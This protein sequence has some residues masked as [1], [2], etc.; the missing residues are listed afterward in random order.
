[1]FR[2]SGNVSCSHF[3]VKDGSCHPV[4]HQQCCPKHCTSPELPKPAEI[5]CW[6]TQT[7]PAPPR[8]P[9]NPSPKGSGAQTSRSGFSWIQ[10]GSSYILKL[11]DTLPCASSA[12]GGIE[13]FNSQTSG[14]RREGRE[15][16]GEGEGWDSPTSLSTGTAW[17][18]PAAK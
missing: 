6:D 2:L 12:P 11:W 13:E 18:L 1:M 3:S 10:I 7:C 8:H 4:R 9:C 15:R 14:G 16:D 5:P 17:P